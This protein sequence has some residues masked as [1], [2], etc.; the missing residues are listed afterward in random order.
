MASE[1]LR[2]LARRYG[3]RPAGTP[4]TRDPG[5]TG[6]VAEASEPKGFQEV[7]GHGTEGTP[8]TPQTDPRRLI[9]D[10][11]PRRGVRAWLVIALSG[12][13]GRISLLQVLFL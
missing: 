1:A 8:G 7:A 13:A 5:A 4:G 9:G 6:S 11:V 12:G 10:R 2:A 3:E